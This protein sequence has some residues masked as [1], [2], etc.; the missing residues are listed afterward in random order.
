MLGMIEKKLLT[1]VLISLITATTDTLD[2]STI[3]R[4]RKYF[5]LK[6]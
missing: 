5:K 4:L 2:P 3:N 1:F 6:F